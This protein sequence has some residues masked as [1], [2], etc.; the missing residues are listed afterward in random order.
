MTS[1]FGGMLCF[2]DNTSSS[3]A[4]QPFE[5]SLFPLLPALNKGACKKPPQTSPSPRG[6]EACWALGERHPGNLGKKKNKKTH[7]FH[8]PHHQADDAEAIRRHLCGILGRAFHQMKLPRSLPWYSGETGG[9]CVR[10]HVFVYVDFNQTPVTHSLC[11]EAIF[12]IQNL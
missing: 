6:A 2:Q 7:L 5:D 4:N 12:R 8:R 3:F 11:L 10:G 1:V 9:L